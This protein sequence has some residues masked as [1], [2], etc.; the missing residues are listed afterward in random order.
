[1][2]AFYLKSDM[3]NCILLLL[4]PLQSRLLHEILIAF[5]ALEGEWDAMRVFLMVKSPAAGGEGGAADLAQ[6]SPLLGLI[7]RI[8]SWH[9]CIL[10]QHRVLPFERMDTLAMTKA[11][12]TFL[13]PHRVLFADHLV[14]LETLLSLEFHAAEFTRLNLDMF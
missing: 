2:H 14:L 13:H 5:V 3:K 8:F 10:R 7:S 4:M 1:M 12:I 6:G 9:P 11:K